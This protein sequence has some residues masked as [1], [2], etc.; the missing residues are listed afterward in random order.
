MDRRVGGE[1]EAEHSWLRFTARVTPAASRSCAAHWMTRGI[2]RAL[3]SS[4]RGGRVEQVLEHL[5]R[6]KGSVQATILAPGALASEV[7]PG[8]QAGGVGVVAADHRI[9]GDSSQPAQVVGVEA[10]RAKAR[11]LR[12]GRSVP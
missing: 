12:D 4:P 10:Q 9:E 7:G 3:P 11:A 8:A 5:L 1:V 6:E 2:R